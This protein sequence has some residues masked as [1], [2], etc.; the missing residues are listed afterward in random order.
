M[1]LLE[2]LFQKGMARTSILISIDEATLYKTVVCF[3]PG[4]PSTSKPPSK[5]YFPNFE[6]K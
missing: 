5:E 1:R 3:P 4:Q 6:W 2:E